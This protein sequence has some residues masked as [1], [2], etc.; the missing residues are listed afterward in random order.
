MVRSLI[1]VGLAAATLVTV[2]A[3]VLGPWG[4][5]IPA[6]VCLAL[7]LV[8]VRD[9]TQ[10]RHSILRNFPV[11]G[12][13]RFFLEKIR[14]EIQQYFIERNYDGRPF[15]R[16]QRSLVYSR[17]KGFKGDKAFG[18][19]L[20][21]NAP[22]YEYFVQS[23]A[24]KP[25]PEDEHRVRLGGPDC[26]LPYDASLL[27]ISSMSFGSLSKNAVLAMNK[28]AAK[29][30][31]AQET[32]EGGLTGYHLAHDAD[33][34]W[35]FGSG[36]FGTRDA[37]G[38]F[39]PEIFR[40]KATLPQVKAINIKLSQ[41][42]KP[43]LGGVL[44]GAK[45]TEEIAE[46]RGVPVGQT[47]ISPASHSAFTTPRELIRFIARLREL[48]DGKPI[49]FK[50]CVGSRVEVLAMCKAMIEEGVTPDF[51]VVDGS[52][53]GTGAAPLEYQDHV[54]TPLVEGLILM[55]NALVGSGLRE[56]IKLGCAGKITSGH[57]IVR[58]I[59]QGADFCMS[60]RAMMMAVGC[61][62]AQA[63]HTNKCPVGVTTQN[64]QLYK[65]LDVEDKGDRVERYHRLTVQEAGQIISTMGC[66]HPEELTREMLRR[67]VTATQSISYESLYRWL[68]PGELFDG[69]EG[70]W[71]EDWRYADPDRFTA[72]HPGKY[73][74]N[75]RSPLVPG[76]VIPAVDHA[77]ERVTAG[78][79]AVGAES[80]HDDA[81]ST[82][83]RAATP[84]SGAG[85]G[86]E[87]TTTGT[88]RR[89]EGQPGTEAGAQHTTR[90]PSPDAEHVDPAEDSRTRDPGLA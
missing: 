41:G 19:E 88:S 77:P 39:D 12:H 3:A 26:R 83:T 82:G 11:L 72:G 63:C 67:K 24:P 37:D 21:V 15:D 29:G 66:E 69:V 79:A 30:R 31:F 81:A 40:R 35:E 4:W 53:G 8:G 51:I 32:G 36:Y 75:D 59:I 90:D 16:D 25:A 9:A 65:A 14:P 64:P 34:F 80:H 68:Q 5:W 1:L 52:E 48:S 33:I 20:D 58:H 46:A 54:G 43:G 47:C 60:A 22:G 85:Q 23:I 71:G 57:D 55:H 13:M 27:N 17:A 62:Q 44:P 50:L 49:G 2:L 10:R 56:R 18:T 78:G 6:V 87:D 61:I 73:V 28:G 7:L 74:F 70:G 38:N 42:A 76:G 84:A 45:V 89:P 86:D